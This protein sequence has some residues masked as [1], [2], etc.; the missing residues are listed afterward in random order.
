MRAEAAVSVDCHKRMAE[1]ALTQPV[2]RVGP[3]DN[4][5]GRQTLTMS[6]FEMFGLAPYVQVQPVNT[7]GN[8]GSDRGSD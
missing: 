5:I 6:F 4:I 7:N 8:R 2:L 3:S 1:L